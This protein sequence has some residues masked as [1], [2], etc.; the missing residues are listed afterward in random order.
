MHDVLVAIAEKASAAV[1]A[2][3]NSDGSP[4][5]KEAFFIFAM[6]TATLM[7]GTAPKTSELR[8]RRF[9]NSHDDR[10]SLE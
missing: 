2:F 1:P 8:L 5:Y 7:R 6:A 4:V 3:V 9:V 10:P